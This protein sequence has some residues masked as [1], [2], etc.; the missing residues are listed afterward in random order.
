MYK[1]HDAFFMLGKPKSK[2]N[3]LPESTLLS[4]D[5]ISVLQMSGKGTDAI[6]PSA[7]K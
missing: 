7:F 3:Q 4:E 2:W 1:K 5:A 6:N